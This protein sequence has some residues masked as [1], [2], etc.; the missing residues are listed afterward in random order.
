MGNNNSLN[1]P[2]INPIDIKTS[3][4]IIKDDLSCEYFNN[5]FLI[6]T[7]LNGILFLLYSTESKSIISFDLVY[8]RKINEIKNAHNNFISNFKH[9]KD[10]N[11]K[12]DLIITISCFDNNVKIWNACN[13]ECICN[14][15]SIY[16]EGHLSSASYL[17]DKNQY[18]II[19][20]NTNSIDSKNPIIVFDLNG[21]KIK[22][23]NNSCNKTY[24]IDSF[25]DEIFSTNYMITGNDG[26]VKSFDHNK[27]IL[28]H[29]YTD[30]YVF[31]EHYNIIIYDKS[32]VV[33]MIDFCRNGIIR[34]WDFHG[35][36]LLNRF[37]YDKI[38]I[39]GGCLWNDDYLYVAFDD[40]KIKL[41]SL[42]DGTIVHNLISNEK[43]V[44]Y[45]QKINHPKYGECMVSQGYNND[46]IKLWAKSPEY[47]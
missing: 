23:I 24:F 43:I 14:I 37:I 9:I 7:S 8:N 21:K 36:L 28:Y 17:N 19:V 42:K 38:E 5:S 18:Y 2:N 35:R 47:N 3:I 15:K 31:N 33:K 41:L 44:I 39:F 27:N 29:T 46:H 25:Y 11:N 6:F 13:W 32:N 20:S 34:I 45:I 10:I 30:Y 40:Y 1:G 12:R 22:E 16:L 4:D 26:Y